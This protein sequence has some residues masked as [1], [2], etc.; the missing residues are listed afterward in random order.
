MLVCLP[1]V[2]LIASGL[3]LVGVAPIAWGEGNVIELADWA[4][5]ASVLIASVC[6]LVVGGAYLR[7]VLNR[8]REDF[9]TSLLQLAGGLLVLAFGVLLLLSMAFRASDSAF[10]ASL[11]NPEGEPT[12]TTG[13]LIVSVVAGSVVLAGVLAAAGYAIRQA[14][15]PVLHRFDRSP[16]E[17]DAIG[18]ILRDA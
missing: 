13:T 2:V 9:E 6:P 16:N 12:M 10:Y 17:P 18:T 3:V 4:P 15:T 1:F 11:R 7:S 5:T 14:T 8:T